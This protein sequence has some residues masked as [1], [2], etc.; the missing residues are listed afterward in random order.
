MAPI[1]AHWYDIGGWIAW[2]LDEFKLLF[3]WVLEQIFSLGVALLSAIPVPDWMASMGT[4]QIPSSVAWFAQAFQLQAGA[5]IIASAYLI[6]FIIRRI[7][8]FG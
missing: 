7:P 3:Q 4:L 6:R 5:G 2:L 8:F 1:P